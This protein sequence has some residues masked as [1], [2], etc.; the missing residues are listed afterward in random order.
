[1]PADAKPPRRSAK[2]D[3]YARLLAAAKLTVKAD[4][5]RSRGVPG[6]EHAHQIA[7]QDLKRAVEAVTNA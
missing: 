7:M 3:A 5:Q 6:G 2:T 1:M 4:E